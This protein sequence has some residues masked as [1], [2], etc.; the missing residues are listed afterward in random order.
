MNHSDW[1]SRHGPDETLRFVSEVS[2]LLSHLG[3]STAQALNKLVQNSHYRELVDF[4]FDYTD[5]DCPRDL[6]CARQIQA[7]VSKQTPWLKVGYN[8]KQAGKLAFETAEERCKM[9]NAR[10][11]VARPHGRVA[12]VTHYAQRKISDVLAEVPKLE[13]L[14]FSFGPGA[15]TNVRA[16]V[17]SP[18]AKLAARLACSE[19]MLSCAGDLLAEAPYWATC[20]SGGITSNEGVLTVDVEVHPGKMTLVP[21]N[22]KTT[23]PIVVEPVLNGFAQK[24]IG[25]YLRERLLRVCNQDLKDQTRNQKA[26]CV[27]SITG[28]LATV[29][30]ASA[31]DTLSIGCVFD[32][33]PLPWAEFLSN[34]RSEVVEEDG[35]PRLLEKFSSMGNAF[36]FELETL[37]FYSLA[38]GVCRCLD[39]EVGEVSVYGDDII[40]PSEAFGL[41]KEVLEW[42]G[43]EVNTSK[44]FHEGPFRESCGADWFRGL[45]IRPFYLRDQVSDRT[46][47]TFHNWAMR[48]CEHELAGLVHSWTNPALRL[49]GPDGYGDGHLLGSYHVRSNR[50]TRRDGWEGGF[51]DTYA[52][53][54]KRLKKRYDADWVF[55][56]YS[57]Y[58]R[59]AG[60]NPLDP[61]APVDPDV[62]RGSDGYAKVSIYTLATTVFRG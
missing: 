36:T 53:R 32:L 43:F 1:I 4:K 27:G 46:L 6:Q 39:I 19:S 2:G 18:R 55:P 9:T 52:L 15:S 40:I 38:F 23:R 3:G 24:G 26:A 41:L 21:K 44:S 42:Y 48:N 29:D 61:M 51:F 30:L 62:V 25:R 47:Y 60:R 50:K 49:Y 56:A 13:Q 37:I 28:H 16:A 57:V 5:A 20:H 12:V 17:S 58:T 34:F 10:L 8:A 31:S 45:D 7:L 33:L 22:L 11:D 59:S 35:H 54:P 14:T